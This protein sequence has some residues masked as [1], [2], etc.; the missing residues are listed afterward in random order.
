V[1]SLGKGRETYLLSEGTFPVYWEKRKEGGKLSKIV[2]KKR[3]R[4]TWRGSTIRG[5]RSLWGTP[6]EKEKIKREE[7]W[8]LYIID[9]A[10]GTVILL[11]CIVFLGK[12]DILVRGGKRKGDRTERR[13][14]V[15]LGRENE[16]W[17]L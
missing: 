11:S 8:V 6:L 17:I 13:R 14:H 5:K 10:K 1:F 3:K 15:S 4:G 7:R 2:E 12:E 16:K 9:K